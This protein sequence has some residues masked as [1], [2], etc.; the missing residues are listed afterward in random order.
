[1]KNVLFIAPPAGG[2]G[3]ISDALVE[4]FGY[5]HI[6]TGDLLRELDKSTPLGKEVDELLKTGKLL[7]D[8]LVLKLFKEKLSTI[9]D[10]P[11]ILDG[12]P[13]NLAQAQ[14]CD[15]IF[16]D[17]GLSLDVVIELEV[18]FD[19]IE[20]RALGRVN[21]PRCK[22][23]FNTFFKKPQIED[24][25]DKCGNGLIHRDDDNEETFKIRYDVYIEQTEPIKEFYKNKG[26]FEVVDGVEG[27]YDSVVSVLK[28]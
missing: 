6:S 11:F 10:T 16:E 2:K 9:G 12:C 14:K 28:R 17:L 20:K 4:N 26:I 13:R 22:A 7:D 25:C 18:P 3:T 24:V 8:D 27:T 21:C 1:M 19:I 5:I 15:E 23:T